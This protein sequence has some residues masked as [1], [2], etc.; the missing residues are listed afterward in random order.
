MSAR[1]RWVWSLS[2]I[3]VLAVLGAIESLRS[4]H[5]GLF[6]LSC[7]IVLVLVGL[8]SS[9]RRRAPVAVRSDLA[10]W[11]ETTS[12]ITGESASAVADRALSS[13]RAAMQDD[14]D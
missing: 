9:L 10:V 1:N 2:T 8:A 4:G 14:R 7:S 12:A 3:A 13:Y 6:G 5:V 11:L